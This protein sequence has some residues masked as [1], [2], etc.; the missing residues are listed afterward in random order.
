MEGVR[1][2]APEIVG[3]VYGGGSITVGP[4]YTLA[5]GFVGYAVLSSSEWL[6]AWSTVMLQWRDALHRVLRH[7]RYKVLGTVH[8]E[9]KERAWWAVVSVVTPWSDGECEWIY[10][11]GPH[12]SSALLALLELVLSELGSGA[13][14]V[15]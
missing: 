6:E 15:P 2:E 13:F 9:W 5:R 12:A 7:A 10:S 3:E 11:E 14:A 8:V 4:V 1:S